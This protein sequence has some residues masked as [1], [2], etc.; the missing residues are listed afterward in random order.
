MN[1]I[2]WSSNDCFEGDRQRFLLELIQLQT[3]IL[4]QRE[5]YIL[6][7]LKENQNPQA[8]LPFP[9]LFCTLLSFWRSEIIILSLRVS[10]LCS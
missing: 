1:K 5:I 8:T 3:T 10:W 4:R 9:E 6:S 7:K 2:T